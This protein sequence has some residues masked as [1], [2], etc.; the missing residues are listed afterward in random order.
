MKD[1]ERELQS[2][3]AGQ[4]QQSAELGILQNHVSLDVPPSANR[5][6]TCDSEDILEADGG[7]RTR[8]LPFLLCSHF[9]YMQARKVLTRLDGD[10]DSKRAALAA[11]QA[12]LAGTVASSHAS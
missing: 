11:A 2:L 1:S 8:G 5:G 12:K 6:A 3:R 4:G 9:V 7:H 10:V